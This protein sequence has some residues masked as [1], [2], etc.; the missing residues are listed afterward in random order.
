M[1]FYKQGERAALLDEN[2][3]EEGFPE[4]LVNGEIP[5]EV[6]ASDKKQ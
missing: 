4:L 3:S 6:N 2:E 1:I 5:T